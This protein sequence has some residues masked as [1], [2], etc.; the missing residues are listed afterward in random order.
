MI[1]SGFVRA[2]PY[3]N[4]SCESFM[5]T[6]KLKNLART[7]TRPWSHPCELAEFIEGSIHLHRPCL[8]VGLS[9]SKEFEQ[10]LTFPETAATQQVN[11]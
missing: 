5:K 3:D 10:Q 7:D 4:A 2:N 8:V 9:S 1:P 6:V 11:P